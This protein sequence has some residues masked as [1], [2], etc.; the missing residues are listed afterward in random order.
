MHLFAALA[1]VCGTA[2]MKR[3][4]VVQLM[5]RKATAFGLCGHPLAHSEV[6]GEPGTS[7]GEFIGCSDADFLAAISVVGRYT[8]K[9]A[10]GGVF[11]TGMSL[12]RKGKTIRFSSVVSA[13]DDSARIEPY[14][15]AGARPAVY[16][17]FVANIE[18]NGDRRHVALVGERVALDVPQEGLCR[19]RD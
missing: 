7:W 13:L 16:K 4:P 12:K 8:G 10:A 3:L 1:L 14:L 2:A 6:A 9:L 15:L 19:R 5:E 17:R 11:V 18:R